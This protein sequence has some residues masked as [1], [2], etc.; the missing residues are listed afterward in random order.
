MTMSIGNPHLEDSDRV[1]CCPLGAVFEDY[2]FKG[3][4][5][6]VNLAASGIYEA[7]DSTSPMNWTI[8]SSSKR[9]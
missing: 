5:R 9:S 4:Q 1:S 6:E 8:K 2:R 3:L 7:G